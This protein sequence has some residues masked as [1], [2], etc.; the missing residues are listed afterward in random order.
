MAVPT[1]KAG[2]YANC[3]HCNGRFWVPEKKAAPAAPGS[4]STGS[5]NGG[6]S[7]QPATPPPTPLAPTPPAPPPPA[8]SS[9]TPTLQTPPPAVNA[10]PVQAPLPG[11]KVARFVSAEA[12]QSTLQASED[13]QLPEL[14]LQEGEKKRK[15]QARERTVSPAVLLGV[16][17]LSVVLSMMMVLSGTGPEDD[18]D[19]KAEKRV[20]IQEKH[21]AAAGVGGDLEH[22]PPLKPYQRLLREAQLAHER[23][24]FRSE[25]RKYREVLDLLRQERGT[26]EGAPGTI[27]RRFEGVTGS[28]EDDKELEGWIRTL[29]K[30]D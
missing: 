28:A 13:G 25:R 10:P 14:Q 15:Q 27:G 1:K 3:P 16:L 5:G 8:P 2:S 26:I 11:R 19:A 18:A 17:S 20:L 24:N 30:D 22:A 21:F 4:A 6:Q 9:Q 7:P 12:A 23:N 29:L